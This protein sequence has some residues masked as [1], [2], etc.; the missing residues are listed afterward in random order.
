MSLLEE[1]IGLSL[2]LSHLVQTEAVYV[3]ADAPASVKNI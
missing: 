2:A 3:C 1:C